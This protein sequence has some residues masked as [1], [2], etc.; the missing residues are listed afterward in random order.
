MSSRAILETVSQEEF[1]PGLESDKDP[2]RR[3]SSF[4]IILLGEVD[5]GMAL[6][7]A[8]EEL[9]GPKDDFVMGCSAESDSSQV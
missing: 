3:F 8:P 5:G 4:G 2:F 6:V 9:F 7:I 1:K